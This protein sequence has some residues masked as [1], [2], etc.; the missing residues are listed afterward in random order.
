MEPEPVEDCIQSTLASLY[1]PFE[2]TAPTLLGQ[3]FQVVERTYGEDALRYTL[4]FLVPAKH[5]LSRIQQEAC[6]Q[7]SGFL[8]LHEGWPLC[9]HE[10]VVVQLASLPWQ[11][12]QPGDFYL[13]VV[14]SGAQAPHLALKCLAPGGRQVQ[15]LP[16]PTDACAFLFTPEWLQ[17]INKDRTAGRLTTCL[18]AAPEGIQRLPWAELVCPRF[19]HKG[20]LMVGHHLGPPP[21]EPLS[22]PPPEVLGARSPGD[23]H[24]APVETPE[25]EY[26]E[27]LEVTLPE[28][29][30]PGAMRE[31]PSLVRTHTVPPRKGT[32]GRG[33]H[34]R[35]RAW[36]HQRGVT[37]P[38]GQSGAHLLEE[39]S[40][41]AAPSLPL[42]MVES[43]SQGE[44]PGP[45][46]LPIQ[47]P[48][49]TELEAAPEGQ[50]E[51]EEEA[52]GAKG[53]PSQGDD[54]LP[55]TLEPPIKGN[56]RKNQEAGPESTGSRTG[57]SGWEGVKSTP[58][59][60]QPAISSDT[61][62][63]DQSPG[64]SPAREPSWPEKVAPEPERE[65]EGKPGTP[66]SPQ[67]AE[68]GDREAE[69]SGQSLASAEAPDSKV[70]PDSL[71]DAPE[72]NWDLLSSGLLLLTGGVDQSGRAL[73][74]IT[75]QDTAPESQPSQEELSTA[76][77][78]FHSLLRSELQTL[79]LSVLLD[80]RH[81]AHHPPLPLPPGL[82]PALRDLQGSGDPVLIQRLL[83]LTQGDPPT[84][85]ADL[86]QE[87]E[88][89]L[90]RDLSSLPEQ[91]EQLWG[92]RG[93]RDLSPRAWAEIHRE[94]A[95]LSQL[96]REVLRSVREAIEELE[97]DGV[98][99]PEKEEE[100]EDEEEEEEDKEEEG[101]LG[102]PE[103]LRKLLEDPRLA[104]LQREGGSTLM[105]LRMT[106]SSSV[107]GPAPAVLY[108]EVDEAIHQLVRLSNQH[109]QRRER[110]QQRQRQRRALR[111]LRGPGEEQ[112][113]SFGELGDS[114][115]SLQEAELRFQAFGAEAQEQLTQARS[116][117]TQEDLATQQSLEDFEQ[118]LEQTESNLHRALRLHRFFQQVHQWADEGAARIADT[119][120]GPGLGAGPGP[121]PGRG[122]P[123]PSAGAF[124]EMRA[125]AVELGQP[126]ALREWGRCRARCRELSRRPSPEQPR[127]GAEAEAE[128]EAG[129]RGQRRGPGPG[130]RRRA[131]PKPGRGDPQPHPPSPASSLGSLLGSGSPE[132]PPPP[133]LAP[134]GSCAEDSEEEQEEDD[135]EEEDGEEERG[136]ASAGGSRGRPP[137]TVQIRGLEVSSTEVVDR[138]CSPREHVLLG[139][140]GAPEGP[141]GGGTPILERKRSL[142]AQKRL[143]AELLSWE[144]EYVCALG[145]PLAP[146]GPE[147]KAELRE[148]WN[149]VLGARER[150]HRFHR[151]HFLPELQGCAARPL[152]VGACFLRYGDQFSMYTQYMK[153][154]HELETMLT[155]LSTPAKG[156][157]PS[158]PS[159][160]SECC[161][162]PWPLQRP[163]EQLGHYG[164][165][166]RELLQEAGSERGPEHQA[167]AAALQLLQDQEEEG[168]NLLAVEAVRGCEV[169]LK[170]QGP[171]LLRDTFTV[172][173]GRRKSLRHVFLFE[174]LLLF[175][176]PKGA[177]GSA[178]PFV[179]KQAFQTADMGMT[180]NIGD[181]GLCFELWFRRRRSRE[182]Y[183]LQAAS[184]ERKHKWTCAI[185]QLL[186]RQAAHSKDI[187]VQQMVSMGLGNK[188]F[189]DI[190]ALGERTLSSLLTGRAART[191]A[192][193][194]TPFCEPTSP[195][196][197]GLSPGSCSLPARIEEATAAWELDVQH[198]SLASESPNSSGGTPPGSRNISSTPDPHRG[199]SP[200][201]QANNVALRMPWPSHSR[202]SS[203]PI[204]PL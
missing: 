81:P 139:R 10:R 192:S 131:A 181:T 167:L 42:L 4:D 16:V 91:E 155:T 67:P 35:H 44:E 72:V 34:R 18:L 66:A 1:P 186:W 22:P 74:T 41:H 140:T 14:P 47:A 46:D 110:R 31:P 113:L 197:P 85:L 183:T 123:E 124:Q 143:V 203:D 98:T 144:Q 202:T 161:P 3:V 108:Q 7:Y 187:R 12:L 159:G 87:A 111:W 136:A 88:L 122:T 189:L 170:E 195:S 145:E 193:V 62:R 39:G 19:V 101:M 24:N 27:L 191:R 48:V 184:P 204:T 129:P 65:G 73:L 103:P 93:H 132:S 29:G 137:R 196:P 165:L 26:V 125:L 142:G 174:H 28:R 57:S 188:P 49:E 36:L 178:G 166:L 43:S 33:R 154:R 134:R 179:F 152:R 177:E 96:C 11:L 63:E 130:R 68:E 107:E 128:A 82:I 201:A 78:Y 71:S 153:H 138:T 32:G 76:L 50:E 64:S 141:A 109:L 54:G 121:G 168:H 117:L 5:L 2:A 69:P 79:G 114:L 135:G 102:S 172:L 163:L 89:L 148:K 156:S 162:S 25:G 199:G 185:A 92:L 6:A 23:G 52:E 157:G 45:P 133:A 60:T 95:L 21:T 38:R 116:S 120:A 9:L 86:Q 173:C 105:K 160:P 118:R 149:T 190:K 51:E 94:V 164:R 146:A 40:S 84:D 106:H 80:L 59:P 56:R 176:K 147:L 182:A 83:I 55:G 61:P 13:Q 119:G 75:P 53:D 37:E 158:G 20:G 169:D 15:E 151:L 90:E 97:T 175:S 200:H 77:R 30:A 70:T 8:F 58:N 194:A 180:E 100:E 127:R 171:L 17:G 126:S 150:L 104:R 198:I 99:E 115:S 112:L